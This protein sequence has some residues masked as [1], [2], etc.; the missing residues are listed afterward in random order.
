MDKIQTIHL[1]TP[2]LQLDTAR[3]VRPTSQSSL[4]SRLPPELRA[5]VYRHLFQSMTIVIKDSPAGAPRTTYN[6]P[7]QILRTCREYRYEALPYLFECARLVI[8]TP[9]RRMS[10]TPCCFARLIRR[11]SIRAEHLS[12][13]DNWKGGQG[14]LRCI[15]Q[16]GKLK[17]LEIRGTHS[18]IVTR[19]A[20]SASD[21]P[22]QRYIDAITVV[23]KSVLGCSTKNAFRFERQLGDGTRDHDFA[24]F[25]FSCGTMLLHVQFE[26]RTAYLSVGIMVGCVW[27]RQVY[28]SLTL[29]QHVIVDV[30]NLK[31]VSKRREL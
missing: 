22:D 21:I 20:K 3:P 30:G 17:V 27:S 25:D 10:W 12:L 9:F 7:F 15:A 4:F 28:A 19:D 1:C 5:I 23:H 14:E 11:V 26:I 29:H 24:A 16:L 8:H 31:V 13:L 2:R 18:S 6:G